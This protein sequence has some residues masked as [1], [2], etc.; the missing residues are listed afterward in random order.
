LLPSAVQRSEGSVDKVLQAWELS[1]VNKEVEIPPSP[2]KEANA[3]RR[4]VLFALELTLR[5]ALCW[6]KWIELFGLLLDSGVRSRK[7][8]R[9]LFLGGQKEDF[10]PFL[11]IGFSTGVFLQSFQRCWFLLKVQCLIASGRAF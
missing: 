2:R 6:G 9:A 1:L 10:P 4:V 11:A 3:H 5:R 8:N 7:K